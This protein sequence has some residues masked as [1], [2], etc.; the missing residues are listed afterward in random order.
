MVQIE[1]PT[2]AGMIAQLA[3]LRVRGLERKEIAAVVVPYSARNPDGIF[4]SEL[5]P[6]HPTPIRER[7]KIVRVVRVSMIRCLSTVV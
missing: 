7:L 2:S 1:K 5:L 4:V 6:V 3:A